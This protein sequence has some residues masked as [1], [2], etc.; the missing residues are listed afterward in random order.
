MLSSQLPG[1]L[2]LKRNQPVVAPPPGLA[3]PFT[4]APLA[5]TDVATEVV[6]AGAV[7]GVVNDCT[8]PNGGAGRVLGDCAEVVGGARR[9]AAE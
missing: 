7:A 2:A 8:A 4:V 9:Q 1:S 6:T 5:V 3:A